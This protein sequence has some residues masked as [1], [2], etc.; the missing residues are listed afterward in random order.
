MA[1]IGKS[2]ALVPLTS[3]DLADNIVT[4]AKINA[5]AV[6]SAKLP[7]DVI[8]EEHLDPT[9]ITALTEKGTPVDADKLIISDSADSNALKYVQ[10]S[11]LASAADLELV[12]AGNSGSDFSIQNC[13]TSTYNIYYVH[14]YHGRP[15]VASSGSGVHM[16]YLGTS[17]T[18]IT[19][20]YYW[21][22][23]RAY[24]QSSSN[25][26]SAHIGW[27]GTFFDLAQNGSSATASRSWTGTLVFYHPSNSTYHTNFTYQGTYFAYNN[28]EYESVSGG[29]QNI[30]T[31]YKVTTGLKFYQGS[32]T[33]SEMYYAVYG[34]K[35]S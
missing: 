33:I 18:E 35:V 32:S 23:N 29:G 11:N 19:D 15:A 21:S 2:P 1:Y 16:R 31:N 6:T 26:V 20:S 30:N 3:S 17:N 25:G 34:L 14:L 12:T 4:T 5:D 7:D 10:K 13:F 24:A 27:G 28:S 22:F 8:S 9:I